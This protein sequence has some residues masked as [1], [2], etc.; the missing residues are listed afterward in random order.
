M[1]SNDVMMES[2]VDLMWTVE[3]D[4]FEPDGEVIMIN[5]GGGGGCCAGCFIEPNRYTVWCPLL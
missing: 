3:D 2:L 5:C 1:G 4:Q